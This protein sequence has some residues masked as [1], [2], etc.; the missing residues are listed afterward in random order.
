[1]N[2]TRRVTW[3]LISVLIAIA[4]GYAYTQNF[5]K[6]ERGSTE[7]QSLANFSATV[8]IIFL[9]IS[10]SSLLVSRIK[11]AARNQ[12]LN[13]IKTNL[14]SMVQERTKS[15]DDSN[16]LLT[17]TNALLE[18]EIDEHRSTSKALLESRHYLQNILASMP[19]MLIGLDENLEI[20][21]WNHAAETITGFVSDDVIGKYLWDAYTTITISPD[22]VHA[23]IKSGESQ[24]IKHSQ[25]GQYY[26][27]IAI[28]PLQ[29][30]YKGAVVVIDNVTQRS[31]AE[32]MLIQRDKMASMGELA[33]T[34]AHDVSVP[35]KA[36]LEDV[37]QAREELGAHS[38]SPKDV[39]ALLKDASERGQQASAVVDNLI[40]FSNTGTEEKQAYDLIE[41][42][43]KSIILANDML[44]EPQGF[45]FKDIS[46]EKSYDSD[47]PLLQAYAGELQQVYLSLFR[48][49]T[50]ALS[51]RAQNGEDFTPK[52][53]LQVFVAY[54]SMWLKLEHNG[55][56]LTENEQREIFEPF[57][58]QTDPVKPKPVLPENRLSFSYFIVTEHHDGEM[59]VTVSQDGL[60]CFHIQFNLPAA[61]S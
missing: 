34:M 59:A 20:T 47:L 2:L 41:G 1:M 31:L 16:R 25:R 21:H 57:V 6:D 23:V 38:D 18:E 51:E 9:A 43:E 17:E 56:V 58:Q 15:L 52:L 60:T 27:D 42:L 3:S 11:L 48:Q 14:E 30:N 54:E 53:S 28:C 50:K 55:H 24:I 13:E 45:R 29:E 10:L 46:L 7:W 39:V 44:S 61:S 35:L 4:A 5:F 12:E 33:A 36:I 37:D 49:A 26:F 22:Q 32:S 40:G 19:S 8:L